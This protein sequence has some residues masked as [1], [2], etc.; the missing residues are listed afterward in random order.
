MELQE[1]IKKALDYK[2]R[3]DMAEGDEGVELS[4]MSDYYTRLV[5]LK[6]PSLLCQKT[7][8]HADIALWVL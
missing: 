7:K 6:L 5:I 4:L 3:A 1:L 2:D 8:L